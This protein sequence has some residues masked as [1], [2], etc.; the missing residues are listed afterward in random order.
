MMLTTIAAASAILLLFDA[1]SYCSYF[2]YVYMHTSAHYKLHATATATAAAAYG[3]QRNLYDY[4]PRT[5]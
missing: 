1:A 5:T 2:D 4:T 3:T